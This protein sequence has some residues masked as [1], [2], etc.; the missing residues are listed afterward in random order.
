[1]TLAPPVPFG[2]A[3]ALGRTSIA[4][5]G[6]LAVHAPK[7][8]RS[9]L[10]RGL[11][12][13]PAAAVPQARRVLAITAR[14]GQES[15]DLG[16]VL[17]EF[18]RAG[19]RLALLCL[20][21]GEASP[22]NSTCQRLEAIRPWELQAAASILGVSTVM[23]ADFPDGRLSRSPLAA[24]TERVRR[25]I[26]E[27]RPDL[28]LVIDSAAGS[29]GDARVA[30]AVCRAAGA[31]GLPVAARTISGAPG[32]WPLDLG[33]EAAVARAIQRS[34]AAAHVSQSEGLAQVH[35]RLDL[36]GAREHLRWLIRRPGSGKVPHARVQRGT[37]GQAA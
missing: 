28:L 36:L 35:Q 10:T 3:A 30:K 29:P 12:A 27:H 33:A 22:L 13:A 5:A 14:P 6:W 25:A 26:D 34:A 32:S 18:H 7:D 16:G 9:A 1:M 23:V 37:T 11:H 4:Q 21:R 19:A 24:L 31:V 20:T 8:A 2:S 15:A 17:H